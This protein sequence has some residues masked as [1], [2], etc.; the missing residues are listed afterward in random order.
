MRRV[1][2]LAAILA[3]TLYVQGCTQ[4][5]VMPETPK[6]SVVLVYGGLETAYNTL[7]DRYDAGAIDQITATR[8]LNKINK[9][10][11]YNDMAREAAKTGDP[12]AQAY[13]ALAER[14][15]KE[16]EAALR[17]AQSNE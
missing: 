12:D 2:L 5:P 11:E 6:Q 8:L 14:L 13:L 15:L 7:V 16:V 10:D 4:P 9:A 17:E 1:A 3:T